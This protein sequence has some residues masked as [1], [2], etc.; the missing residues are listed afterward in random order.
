MHGGETDKAITEFNKVL[1][2]ELRNVAALVGLGITHF[3][4]GHHD[5]ALRYYDKALQVSRRVAALWSRG[6]LL[7]VMGK[8]DKA[9]ADCN[10]AITT[11]PNDGKAHHCRGEVYRKTSKPDQAIADYTEAIQLDPQFDMAYFQRG[12]VLLTQHKNK[13]AARD[14]SRHIELQPRSP[15]GYRFRAI[16]Y[17]T[18]KWIEMPKPMRRR[19]KS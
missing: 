13:E 3:K 2:M 19:P 14:F 6:D 5:T 12:Y 8:Y 18:L 9:L 16:A 17:R 4:Q 10:K 7:T 11:G 15:H 1:K